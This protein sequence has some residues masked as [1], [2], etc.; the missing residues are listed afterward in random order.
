MK[1]LPF[2]I[3]FFFPWNL[4]KAEKY[5]FE[6]S[7]SVKSNHVNISEKLKSTTVSIENRWTDSFGEYGVG[8]CN[9]HIL[10]ENKELS[11]KVY[12]EQTSS[13]GDKF[14]TQLIRDKGLN[15][16]IGKIKFLNGTG[17]YQRFIGMECPYA[18]NYLN[19]NINFFKQVCNV[20]KN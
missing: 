15:A 16:G 1:Y 20:S 7:S 3:I 4:L 18:V 8:K 9:G 12:C 2:I 5:I 19:D 14:W 10:T 6:S 11:L 17:K 13:S